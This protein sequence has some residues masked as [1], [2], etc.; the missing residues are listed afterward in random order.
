MSLTNDIM[1]LKLLIEERARGGSF[2]GAQINTN[3]VKDIMEKK[4]EEK[5]DEKKINNNNNNTNNISDEEPPK[6]KKSVF[7]MRQEEKEITKI[8]PALIIRERK[9][10]YRS[11]SLCT[12]SKHRLY[13]NDPDNNK[14][15]IYSTLDFHLLSSFTVPGNGG[16]G[17]IGVDS[18]SHIYVCR[19]SRHCITVITT[20]GSVVREIGKYGREQGQLEEPSGLVVDTRDRIF[21]SDR[22]NHRI[23]VFRPDGTVSRQ[24]GFNGMNSGQFESPLSITRDSNDQIYVVDR[25]NKRVQVFTN[26]GVYIRTTCGKGSKKPTVCDSPYELTSTLAIMLVT[27]G[28]RTINAY[29]RDSTVAWTFTAPFDIGAMVFDHPLTHLFVADVTNSCIQVYDAHYFFFPKET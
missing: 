16:I 25:G 5:K 8:T 19:P 11:S 14:I 26:A 3:N 15:W 13:V 20:E 2:L 22:G 12:D 4:D 27:E 9:D 21:V 24:F 28:K 1:G 17:A 10:P 7:A 18:T 23:Q 29:R 6:K